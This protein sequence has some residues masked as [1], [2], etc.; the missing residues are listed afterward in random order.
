[1]THA[2]AARLRPGP[3]G[4]ARPPPVKRLDGRVAVVT[5]AASGI[6]AAVARCLRAEGCV[7]VAVDRD[8]AVMAAAAA[9]G[10]TARVVD[11]AEPAEV[12]ALAAWVVETHGAV[13]ILVNNAGITV[14]GTFEEHSAEDFDRVMRVNL[15]GVVNGCRAFL[16]HLRA[17]DEA[18]IVNLSSVFGIVAIP[19]QSAYCTSK[20]AVRGFSEALGE[21]LA[22]SRVGLTVV[23]PGGVRT[24]I[25]VH[26]TAAAGMARGDALERLARFFAKRTP[27]PEE[28]A[29]R[30][31]AAIRA[32]RRR[33]LVTGDAVLLDGLRRLAPV[34]SNR[35]VATEILRRLGVRGALSTPPTL[36]PPSAGR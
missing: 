28:V 31:V 13:H 5:G 4:G 6:G 22:G 9:I 2:R 32:G 21:E 34:W 10:A 23:H 18:H 24:N 7:V 3:S 1:M 35:V 30:I 15:G 27:P 29:P 11:V 36:P 25:V 20:F 16:P 19:G 26:A 33:A 8:P 14:I 17:A 12:E